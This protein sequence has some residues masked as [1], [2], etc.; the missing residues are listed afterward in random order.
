MGHYDRAYEE[1]YAE[2]RARRSKEIEGIAAALG[3][4]VWPM[5]RLEFKVVALCGGCGGKIYTVEG[6]NQIVPCGCRS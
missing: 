4:P 1:R 3:V 6:Y 2:D 5:G